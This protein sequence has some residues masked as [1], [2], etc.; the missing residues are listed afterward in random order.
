MNSKPSAKNS[1]CHKSQRRGNFQIG[2][3]ISLIMFKKRMNRIQSIRNAQNRAL[4]VAR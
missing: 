3:K 2:S 1:Q 4:H